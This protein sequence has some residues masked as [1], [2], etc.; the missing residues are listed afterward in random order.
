MNA[1]STIF[2]SFAAL[3]L[4]SLAIGSATV[5]AIAGTPFQVAI[6]A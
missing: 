2:A 6:N 1:K 3:L 4:S 5:P